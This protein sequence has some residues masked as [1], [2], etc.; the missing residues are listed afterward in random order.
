MLFLLYTFINY[1]PPALLFKAASR[2]WHPAPAEIAPAA[3]RFGHGEAPKRTVGVA[4]GQ[5]GVTF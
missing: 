3:E 2:K 5:L 1:P 4:G